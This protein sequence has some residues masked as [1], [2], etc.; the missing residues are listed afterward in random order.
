MK[1]HEAPKF[2]PFEKW[3]Q[4][5]PVAEGDP[6][7]RYTNPHFGYIFKGQAKDVWDAAVNSLRKTHC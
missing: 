3:W 2:D 1:E 4:S 7:T 6:V 5:L